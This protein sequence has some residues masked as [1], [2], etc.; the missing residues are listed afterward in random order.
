MRMLHVN[1]HV[2]AFKKNSCFYLIKFHFLAFSPSNKLCLHASSVIINC[3]Q[4]KQ[5]KNSS[6]DSISYWHIFEILVYLLQL[7]SLFTQSTAWAFMTILTFLETKVY[8]RDFQLLVRFGI[9]YVLVGDAVMINLLLPVK[10]VDNRL[11]VLI[12][13]CQIYVNVMYA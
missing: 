1:C 12:F 9:A 6:G 13:S 7:V 2:G 10:Y 3:L 8:I 5:W 4:V 11:C